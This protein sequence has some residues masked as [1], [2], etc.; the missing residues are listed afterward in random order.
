M[1]RLINAGNCQAHE[2]I[3]HALAAL[4]G[5]MAGICRAGGA[6]PVAQARAGPIF[7]TFQDFLSGH[8]LVQDGKMHSSLTRLRK[9]HVTGIWE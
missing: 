8:M 5:E 7:E 9:F 1:N 4:A 3:V 2:F 6:S